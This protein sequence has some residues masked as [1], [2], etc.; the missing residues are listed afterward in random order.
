MDDNR[1]EIR[2]KIQLLLELITLSLSQ[3]EQEKEKYETSGKNLLAELEKIR[4]NI[5]AFVG[6]IIILLLTLISIEIIEKEHVWY[7]IPLILIG[8]ADYFGLNILAG[9]IYKPYPLIQEKFTEIDLALLHLRGYLTGVTIVEELTKEQVILLA[10]FISVIIQ[11]Y[12]YEL[13]YYVVKILKSPKPQQE[14]YRK[15]YKLAKLNIEQF[16]KITT[17]KP[18]YVKKVESFIKEF[19]KNEKGKRKK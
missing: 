17:L 11:S 19:E 10:A 13:G 4:N 15:N 3:I 7:I 8:G 6:F 2:W 9:K 1:A 5:L 18:E 12:T 16:K 14:E